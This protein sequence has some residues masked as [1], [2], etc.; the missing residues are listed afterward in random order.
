LFSYF[1]DDSLEEKI[2]EESDKSEYERLNYYQVK[3]TSIYGTGYVSN[4]DIEKTNLIFCIDEY[5]KEKGNEKLKNA[6]EKEKARKQPKIN[7]PKGYLNFLLKEDK[8][9][10]NEIIKT[11]NFKKQSKTI[12]NN[13]LKTLSGYTNRIPKIKGFIYKNKKD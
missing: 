2:T 4:Y 13:L 11:E 6:V 3:T 8:T 12:I 7:T 5:I 1:K 10:Y 9:I